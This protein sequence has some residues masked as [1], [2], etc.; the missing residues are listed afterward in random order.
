MPTCLYALTFFVAA[1][2]LQ[3]DKTRVDCG[4]VSAT[5]SLVQTFQLTNTGAV[6]L[7]LTEVVGSCG[8]FRRELAARELAPG[9]RTTL[10]VAMNLLT[11]PEG[12]NSW[13]VTVRY[14]SGDTPG[15]Q[16]IVL[17]A[18]VLKEISVEP[19]SLF[20]ATEK[21]THATLTV[22]DRRAK[23]L[24][25]TEVRT[26]I[27]HVTGTV[28]PRKEGE[29]TQIITV[30]IPERTPTGQH[31][32]E[33]CLV[34]DDPTCPELRIP[35]RLAKRSP[36]D[37]AEVLP[38]S[39]IVRFAQEQT[40]GSVLLRVRAADGKEVVIASIETDHE[41]LTTKWVPGPGA[42]ATVRLTLDR[43][44]LTA[45]GGTIVTVKLRS[46]TQESLAIPLSWTLP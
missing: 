39:A 43:A 6:P 14:R 46:P 25:I 2:P 24:R 4:D 11:V 34:T 21:E 36:H 13:R 15:E 7:Q 35:L 26:G 29:Q 17:T 1:T 44:K 40:T 33:V 23:P 28:A 9:A 30:H 12:V 37:G 5:K 3:I 22:T 16:T 19:V 45:A 10:T 32:D 42:M 38:A 31:A 27:P 20:I 41:A 8:C 18:K